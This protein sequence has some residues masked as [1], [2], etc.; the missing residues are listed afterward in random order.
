[1]HPD[2]QLPIGANT[3]SPLQPPI[4]KGDG[5]KGDGKGHVAISLAEEDGCR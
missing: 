1:M 4:P 2:G 3:A 5:K